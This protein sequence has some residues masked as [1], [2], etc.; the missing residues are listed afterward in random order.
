[1]RQCSWVWNFNIN[2][3]SFFYL[4]ISIYLRQ[5]FVSYKGQNKL[6]RILGLVSRV[7]GISI[8]FVESELKLS[9]IFSKMYIFPV[10]FISNLVICFFLRIL[11]TL[12]RVFRGNLLSTRKFCRFRYNNIIDKSNSTSK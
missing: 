7:Y 1:M 12:D 9:H 5:D 10:F 11:R 4:L 6:D 8:K 3:S 2:K